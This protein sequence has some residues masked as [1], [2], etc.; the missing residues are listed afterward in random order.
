MF[1]D[2]HRMACQPND[3]MHFLISTET[4]SAEKT[5]SV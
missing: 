5:V 2:L 4:A 3:F 1:I